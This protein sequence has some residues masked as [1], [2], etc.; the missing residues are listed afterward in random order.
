[1][2]NDYFKA[3]GWFKDYARN[4]QDSRGMFQRLVK[5][6]EEAFRIASAETD[7]IKAMINK[8]F[9]SGTMKYGSEIPQ[10][11]TRDDVIQI[12]ALNAFMKRNPAAEGGRIPFG[13]GG[14]GTIEDVIK[15]YVKQISNNKTTDNFSDWLQK[16]SPNNYNEYVELEKYKTVSNAPQK[17]KLEKIKF[18]ILEDLVSDAN[19]R[20]EIVR[21]NDLLRLIEPV[22]K[23]MGMAK[24]VS[25]P[26]ERIA[27]DQTTLK[28]KKYNQIL[29]KLIKK[30][31]K[32]SN[33]IDNL[34]DGSIPLKH[35]TEATGRGVIYETIL[36]QVGKFDVNQIATEVKKHPYFKS[37]KGQ[38]MLDYLNKA[39]GNRPEFFQGWTLDE[40]MEWSRTRGE[41][42]STLRGMNPNNTLQ[43][44]PK[45]T[46][47][48][49]RWMHRHW[50]QNKFWDKKGK[51]EFF[52]K[53]SKK[54]IEWSSKTVIGPNT[55]DFSY[56][57][58][59]YDLAKL[60]REYLN[61]GKGNKTPFNEFFNTHKE[62]FKFLNKSVPGTNKRMAELL[63][64]AYGTQ[65]NIGIDHIDGIMK[66][67]IKNLRL[68]N[69]RM[70][71]ALGKVFYNYRDYP[72][73]KTA[74]SDIITKNYNVNNNYIDALAK[75]EIKL[76]KNILKN[77]NSV[78]PSYY[79]DA[80]KEL[81]T[82]KNYKTFNP[83]ERK[84]LFQ[85]GYKSDLKQSQMKKILTD[86]E[87]TKVFEKDQ[88]G[89]ATLKEIE[90]YITDRTGKVKQPILP[91][92][93]AG[94]YE[95]AKEDLKALTNSEAYKTW[96]AKIANPALKSAMVAAK[97]PTKIFGAADLV[98]GYLD[99]AN[100]RQKGFSKE[101]STR[102]MVDAVLFGATS[103]GEKGDIEGVKK[104]AMQ[105]GMSE[106]VFN[107][108]VSVNTNQKAMID[109]INESKAAFNE[110]MDLIESGVA[111]P[112]TEKM[113]IQKLKKDTNTFLAETMRKIVDDS[114]SLNTNLQVEEAG[115]PID[116][117]VDKQQQKAFSDLGKSSR[118]F[119]QKRIDASDLEKIAS[120]K[121]TTK[122]GIGDEVMSGVKGLLSQG[123]FAY[124]LLNPLSPLPKWDD[125][126]PKDLKYKEQMAKLK[127]EDPTMYYKMLMSEGVDPRINLN[128]PVQLE[129]E[130][131]YPQF[132]TQLS[133]SLTQNKAEGG[134]TEL[135]SKYE[136]KK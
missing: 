91:S 33:V 53:G 52:K 4:S 59:R 55:H 121:D 82:S 6:D 19:T 71:S 2:S 128:I 95:F 111:D 42:G 81:F 84:M 22:R 88:T 98:L 25:Y 30:E 15:I 127:K 5:E 76:A 114:R 20:T 36:D 130:Q 57:G 3:Q 10:P 112:A 108:L 135:R 93:L 39:Y 62:Y 117:N 34:I 94:A 68:M 60:E 79:S 58:K 45:P 102:H 101:D 85:T 9:G 133:D 61:Y 11:A 64:D 80:G 132:G 134:I 40:L 73:I 54:P 29:K 50:D 37:K 104:I 41:G 125:W 110:S 107:N 70:N 129:F 115:A 7:R 32:I 122:G 89:K 78:I 13:K 136:Y 16:N 87:I 14:S 31:K 103:F 116:I 66:D 38:K 123:K 63:F 67:P 26:V 24:G 106:E 77:G 46:A 51:V 35:T 113:L 47:Q 124:D 97:L 18:K 69:S 28:A 48:I 72:K 99:Y 86:S 12:D 120:Q 27:I 100:N 90:A 49:Y 74:L 109:R 75:N 105:N 43:I 8:K 17:K 65:G 131:K 118:E 119:V 44:Q 83:T 126:K 92:G 23:E 56:N 21:K 1:M 96:K